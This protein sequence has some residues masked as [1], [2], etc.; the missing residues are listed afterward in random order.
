MK[1][2]PLLELARQMK[3]SLKLLLHSGVKYECPLCGYRSRDLAPI[4]N[5]YE[6]LRRYEVVGAAARRGG[7]Y[8]CGAYDRDKLVFLYLRD[9][10][11]IFASEKKDYHILHIAPS[12]AIASRLHAHG[13]ARYLAGDLFAQGYDYPGYV[14]EMNVLSLPFDDNE[15][16]LVLCNHV[17]EHIEDDRRA[18]REIYRVMKA[19]ARAVLQVPL[20]KVLK[21]SIEDP[22]LKTE[23]ERARAF[24]Q[25]DH[26]R[27]YGRDYHERL[28][29]CGFIVEE[30]NL[31]AAYPRQGLNPE[32]RLTVAIKTS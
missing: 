1:E 7:C 23:E 13:F 26:V 12:H 2:Q 19:G 29:E 14:K 5:D 4:G 16:N 31:S 24:G 8:R 27:I 32:E 17:L 9:E 21:E 28:R 6:V 11:G 20:S 25:R 30:Q 18:M 3:K 15:F 22:A 10:L